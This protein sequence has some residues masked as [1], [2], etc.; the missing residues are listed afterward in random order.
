[1]TKQFKIPMIGISL[2]SGLLLLVSCGNGDI[3][4]I[5]SFKD[6]N[7]DSINPGA[8]VLFDVDETLVQP[9][10]SYL[11]N[12]NK[13]NVIAFKKNIMKM[14]PEVKDWDKMGS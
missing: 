10:D 1:M 8:L 11:L 2:W 13:K 9:V 6:V 3:N 12:E 7:F 4:S 5:H 14:H